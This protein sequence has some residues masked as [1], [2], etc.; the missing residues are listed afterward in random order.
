MSSGLEMM[1]KAAGIDIGKVMADFNS[2]KTGVDTTLTQINQKLA[3]IE[4][5]VEE[6]WKLQTKNNE[7]PSPQAPPLISPES[8]SQPQAQPQTN[9]P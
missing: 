4:T 8:Q 6:L 2:L 3:R 7:Q 9:Q 5:R 1:L